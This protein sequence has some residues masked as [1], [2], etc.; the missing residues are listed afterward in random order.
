MTE[1]RILG[2]GRPDLFFRR[3][4]FQN[5][6]DNKQ[7]TKSNSTLNVELAYQDKVLV[8]RTHPFQV[9]VY[10]VNP[11]GCDITICGKDGEGAISFSYK[12]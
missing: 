4:V 12:N 6:F 1:Q 11:P 3:F 10:R 7:F 8:Q 5:A 2:S 9:I